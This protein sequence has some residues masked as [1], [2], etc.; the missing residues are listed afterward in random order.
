[1]YDNQGLLTDDREALPGSLS[2][3]VMTYHDKKKQ[4]RGEGVHSSLQSRLQSIIAGMSAAG[5]WLSHHFHR[6]KQ[7]E[8]E[9]VLAYYPASFLYS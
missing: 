3:A 2:A 5:A 7:R 6:Q 9:F 1:M 8:N 4:G